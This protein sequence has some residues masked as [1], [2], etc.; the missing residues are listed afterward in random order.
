VVV[1]DVDGRGPAAAAGLR[2]GDVIS[3]VRDQEIEGLA[4]F[5]RKVWSSG[6][7]GTEIP[8]RVVRGKRD[9]WLRIKSASRSNFLKKPRLQ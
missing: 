6:P 9:L 1:V 4:N 7:A 8:I 2:E 5:Y 3:D